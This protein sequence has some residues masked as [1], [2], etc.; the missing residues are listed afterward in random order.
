M[1]SPVKDMPAYQVYVAQ[2]DLTVRDL[3]EK[4]SYLN[5]A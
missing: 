2:L 4:L 5:D 1:D 3:M